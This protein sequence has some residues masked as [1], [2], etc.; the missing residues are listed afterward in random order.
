MERD[1]PKVRNSEGG[2]G[3]AVPIPSRS[4]RPVITGQPAFQQLKLA[5]G[6][7]SPL[8]PRPPFRP[9]RHGRPNPHHRPPRAGRHEQIV[10]TSSPRTTSTSS[11][12]GFL[13][14]KPQ[15]ARGARACT[16]CR[17]AKASLSRRFPNRPLF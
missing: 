14:S 11:D 3:R 7:S 9:I 6:H 17:A 12:A 15:V 8:P 10:R 4:M 5:L 1:P 16:V 13:S 2:V